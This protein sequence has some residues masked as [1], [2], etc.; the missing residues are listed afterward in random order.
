[1]VSRIQT[2][3]RVQPTVASGVAV[4]QGRSGRVGT[5]G[6]SQ[7]LPLSDVVFGNSRVIGGVSSVTSLVGNDCH[8]LNPDNALECEVGL[9]ANHAGKF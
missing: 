1:M 5:L 2:R 7:V 6:D 8:G 3:D 4:R 9:V